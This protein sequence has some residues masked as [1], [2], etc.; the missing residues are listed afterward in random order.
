MT[1]HERAPRWRRKRR[2]P[3]AAPEAPSGRPSPSEAHREAQ[4]HVDPAVRPQVP[5]WGMA[6][7]DSYR[8]KPPAESVRVMRNAVGEYVVEEW[9]R[10]Y[11]DHGYR[12]VTVAR[13]GNEAEAIALAESRLERLERQHLIRTTPRVQVWP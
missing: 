7:F 4:V 8:P 6:D 1:S 5:W 10:G 12:W 3:V 13:H 11:S 2:E 9:S